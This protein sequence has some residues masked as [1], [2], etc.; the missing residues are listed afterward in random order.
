MNNINDNN[1]II[2]YI[3]I[4]L[5]AFRTI[6]IFYY[7]K[8]NILFDLFYYQYSKI[9]LKIKGIGEHFIFG[10]DEHSKFESIYY[11]N[12]IYI[13]GNKESKINYKYYFWQICKI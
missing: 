13:N 2:K 10:N 12:E 1:I 9:T 7:V 11:P 4:N 6:N 8:S 3:L 5:I